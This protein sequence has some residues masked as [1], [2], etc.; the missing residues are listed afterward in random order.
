MVRR[1][2]QAFALAALGF[3]LV[4]AVAGATAREPALRLPAGF[5]DPAPQL[6]GRAWTYDAALWATAHAVDG[7]HD[8][9]RALL[10]DLAAAQHA[11]GAID[12]S[13]DVA[14]GEGAG[15]VR[16]GVVAWLGIAAAQYRTSTCSHRYDALMQS[17]AGWLLAQRAGALVRGGP[18]VSWISTEHNLDARAFLAQLADLAGGRTAC[19]GGLDGRPADTLVAE[20]D[21][22]VA[23]MDA[24]I[25]AQLFAGD[26]FRQGAGD[27]A[28]PIDV[29]AF[30]ALWLLGQGRDTEAAAV[31]AYADRH[32]ALGNGYRPYAEDWTP[33]VVW[34]EGTLQ[35]RLAKS[36]IGADTS[37]IDAAVAALPSGPG[38]LAHADRAASHQI[39]DYH[40]WLASAPAAWQRLA[41]NGFTLLGH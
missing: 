22:A 9:A 13:F 6:E 38:Y 14:S 16:S 29:Q 19:P 15:P 23:G 32:H 24:A 3:A 2:L 20:L 26:H 28:R 4:A 36:A 41:S 30:G 11:D 35:M 17:V 27:A 37:A 21:A 31:V 8:A 12:N 33:A 25:D 18:D 7:Q 40:L 34:T 5:L 10:D 39:G 1:L